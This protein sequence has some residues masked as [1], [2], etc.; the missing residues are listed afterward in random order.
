MLKVIGVIGYKDS[1]KTTLVHALAR[2]LVSR[3][4]K[5]AVIKHM[6]HPVDLADKDTAMLGKAVDQVG[7]ISPQESGILWKRELDLEDILAHLEAQFVLVEGFKRKTTFPKIVCL[8]GEP[9]DQELFDGLVICAVGPTD[10]VEDVEVP[11]LGWHEIGK[12]ADLAERRGFMLPGLDCGECGY[13]RCSGLAHEIVAGSRSAEDCVPLKSTT[14]VRIDGRQIPLNSFVSTMVRSTVLG[15][16]SP[17]KGFRQG[18]VEIR[19]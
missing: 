3:G 15:L 16:L 10:Q 7:F 6:S 4:H 14:E 12:I 9:D 2:E 13:E 11:H 1:G 19:F 5:V 17:L 18:N 8:R